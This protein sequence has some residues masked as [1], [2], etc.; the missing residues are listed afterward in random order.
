MQAQ[1]E[2]RQ[3]V[4]P[5]TLTYWRNLLKQGH[6]SAIALRFGL[7]RKEITLAFEGLAKPT[8]INSINKYYQPGPEK[9]P[10]G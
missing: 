5:H 4:P 1:H 10:D 2:T 3:I 7:D 6:K 9:K 8:V